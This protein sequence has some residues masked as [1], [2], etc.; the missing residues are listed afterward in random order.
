[1]LRE[2]EEINKPVKSQLLVGDKITALE[3]LLIDAD[4]ESKGVVSLDTALSH[5]QAAGLDLVE[6]TPQVKTPTCKILDYGRM[7][8]GKQ[9]QKKQKQKR[10]QLKE[11]KFTPS[12]DIGDYNVKLKNIKRFIEQGDK[13]KISIRFRGREMQHQNLG[14]VLIDRIKKDMIDLCA[15]DQEA[16]MEGRQM[17]MIISP[18]HK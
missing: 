10:K 9:K 1:V 13:V 6:M 18:K 17:L 5:A 11:L 12:I 3:V 2:E 15:V 16:K 7:T 8:F 4:G 14:A